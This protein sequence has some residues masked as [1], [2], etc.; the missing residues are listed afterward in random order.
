MGREKGAVFFTEDKC[1]HNRPRDVNTKPG[2]SRQVRMIKLEKIREKSFVAAVE[3]YE[4]ITSTNDRALA[5]AGEPNIPLP[6]LI[7][8]DTQTAGRG[9]GSNRW[10]TGSGSLAFS[11]LIEPTWIHGD[12]ETQRDGLR[13][14]PRVSVLTLSPSSSSAPRPPVLISLAVGVA[15]VDALAPLVPGREIGIHWPNDVM[16]DG[17]KLA[18]VLIEAPPGGKHVI[19]V[20][21]NA[22][23]TAADAPA[24]VRQR[25]ATLR[26]ATGST[27]DATELMISL[28][29]CLHKR[30]AELAC[31]QEQIAA[32]TNELCLQRGQRLAVVQGGTRIEG[33]C[34][35]IAVDGAL[36]M[37]CD[38]KHRHVYSGTVETV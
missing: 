35:G 6:L 15:L 12:A 21:I 5:A 30:L 23:N 9:R 3:H 34:L 28:L 4:S 31:A 32:R 38:S 11:L 17:R 2:R 1:L 22:N 36:L 27:V 20:G 14:R 18:G 19:G 16:L 8:A 7:V 24:E 26:D 25:V 37:E 33:R 29:D 13:D 10:W